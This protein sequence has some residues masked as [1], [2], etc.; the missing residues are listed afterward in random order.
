MS[1]DATCPSET[2]RLSFLTLLSTTFGSYLGL[3]SVYW[4]SVKYLRAVLYL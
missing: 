4:K 3:R 2:R 1:D